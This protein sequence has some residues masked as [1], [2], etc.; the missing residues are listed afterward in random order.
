MDKKEASKLLNEIF[1]TDIR[2]EKLSKSELEQLTD[3]LNDPRKVIKITLKLVSVEDLENE[4]T[5]VV[6]KKVRQQVKDRIAGLEI[7][8]Y[9]KKVLQEKL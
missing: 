6:I 7:L 9:A 2:W 3:V 4:I 5:K 1:G 8:E